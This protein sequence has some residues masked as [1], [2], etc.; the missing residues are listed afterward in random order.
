MN[1]DALGALAELLGALGV[2]GSL[3]YLAVQIRNNSKEVLD[4]RTQRIYEMMIQERADF[5]HGPI[6]PIYAKLMS[7]DQLSYEENLR[8]RSYRTTVLNVFE[9]YVLLRNQGKTDTEL[10]PFMNERLKVLFDRNHPANDLNLDDW[11]KTKHMFSKP[12]V[13]SMEEIIGDQ[14]A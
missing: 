13:K 3:I 5:V 14:D 1:W 9:L 4:A 7:G 8:Y 12:F 6:P 10:D 11:M 2:I